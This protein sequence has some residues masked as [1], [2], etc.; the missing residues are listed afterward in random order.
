MY[1]NEKMCH[2]EIG[3]ITFDKLVSL[4]CKGNDIAFI[5]EN[6]K[7]VGGI[8]CGDVIRRI[9][10]E[11]SFDS[12]QIDVRSMINTNIRRLV[13]KEGIFVE[14][15][16]KRIFF[17]Y[18]NIHNIP[19]VDEHG[20]LLYQIDRN[21]KREGDAFV[22][23]GSYIAAFRTLMNKITIK[24]LILTGSDKLSLDKVRWQLVEL[25]NSGDVQIKVIED[26][27]DGCQ[28]GEN[29]Y[30]IS[31]CA[32]GVLYVKKKTTYRA[33]VFSLIDIMRM[34]EYADVDT[35][36]V[37][38]VINFN[39]LF[40]Y[41]IAIFGMTN[42]YN[43]KLKKLLETCGIKTYMPEE[44]SVIDERNIPNNSLDIVFL[45]TGNQFK[46]E[47]SIAE[48]LDIV[49]EL[50]FYKQITS[51]DMTQEV[52]IDAGIEWMR[53]AKN[54]GFYGI[55]LSIFNV[56]DA[57]LFEKLNTIPE[58]HVVKEVH[59]LSAD[60]KY[61]VDRIDYLYYKGNFFGINLKRECIKLLLYKSTYDIIKKKHEKVYVLQV[62]INGMDCFWERTRPNY[63]VNKNLFPDDFV[64]DMFEDENYPV[65]RL[66]EDIAGCEIVNICDGYMKFQSNYQSQYFNTDIY[67]NRVVMD[68]PEEYCGTIWLAGGC[69]FS[70]YAVE[71]TQTVAS[72][73]QGMLNKIQLP[74]RVVNLSADGVIGPWYIY[75]KVL[76]Q[77][78]CANDIVVLCEVTW[79]ELNSRI[80]KIDYSE[81]KKQHPNKT[82]YWDIPRHSCAVVYK[83]VTETIFEY[84]KDELI[85]FEN[86]YKFRV[87]DLMEIQINNYISDTKKYLSKSTVYNQIYQ[88]D[89]GCAVKTGAIVMN[90]NPFTYGHQ[91]LVEIASQLVDILYLF[92]VEEDKSI[93]PFEQRFLMVQEGVKQYKN[94]LVIPSGDFMIS[95][96]TFPGYFM[97]ENPSRACY[98][99][100]LDLKIFAHYVA[101]AFN[102]ESRFVGCEPFDKVTAQYN[103]DMKIILQDQGIMVIEVPRK[104][105]EGQVISATMVRKMLMDKD[106]TKLEKFVPASTLEILKLNR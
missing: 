26:I 18:K 93:F 88:S 27:A 94:V 100:F 8:T 70:G 47:I 42:Y 16:A 61:I 44:Y 102:I 21:E 57:V 83:K 10:Q 25:C 98:D 74:Y 84:I 34:N 51:H 97:K 63:F 77:N 87:D 32:L 90:C 19:V 40:Q 89:Y 29:A 65:E 73:L 105:A 7:L 37:G 15:Q 1:R 99:T 23:G 58:F 106:W 53:V 22:L 20:I 68:A 4:L 31:L 75:K 54:N 85:C 17:T 28:A 45:S 33:Q 2:A 95:T 71:D 50:S 76:E 92:V 46:D 56:L 67:G 80:I 60:K 3:Q 36:D 52:Y 66:L 6:R 14:E 104:E 43:N 41:D 69:I 62:P 96:L 91:Y 103:H 39:H 9:N 48:F 81:I 13:N 55:Y 5:T 86:A 35:I 49:K 78:M 59:E 72:Y 82:W 101:P 24:T 64:K 38:A 79:R 30:V 11:S 12:S